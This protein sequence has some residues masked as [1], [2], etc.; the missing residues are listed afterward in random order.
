GM[1][2]HI[3]YLALDEAHVSTQSRAVVGDIIRDC[4]GFDGL[5]MTDD[6]SMKALSGDFAERTEK[7]LAAGCDIILHCN[8]DFDEMAA[9][10]GALP[11]IMTGKTAERAARVEA[12][13]AGLSSRVHERTQ[14][15]WGELVGHVFPEAQNTV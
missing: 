10:A 5:L 3:T 8:G 1:T 4:I 14:K 15:R 13:I 6:L 12:E 7:A 11:P 9:I 2:A